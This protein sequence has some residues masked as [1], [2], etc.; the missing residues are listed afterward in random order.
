MMK[1]F[2]PL[3]SLREKCWLNGVLFL[4]FSGGVFNFYPIVDQ[5]LACMCHSFFVWWLDFGER[6]C[7]RYWTSLELNYFLYDGIIPG[8]AH[9]NGISP[10]KGFGVFSCTKLAKFETKSRINNTVYLM[11]LSWSPDL[12]PV[13]GFDDDAGSSVGSGSS[14]GHR[15]GGDLVVCSHRADKALWVFLKDKRALWIFPPI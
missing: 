10:C 14:A 15:L 6:D 3:V 12:C 1:H 13:H 7:A 5:N 11:F 9:D 2:S 4:I 8:F